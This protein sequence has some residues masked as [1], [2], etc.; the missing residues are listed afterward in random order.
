ML[1]QKELHA[2]RA[3]IFVPTVKPGR[4][5]PRFQSPLR[6]ASELKSAEGARACARAIAV[7]RQTIRRQRQFPKPTMILRRPGPFP[8]QFLARVLH[9][10]RA[11]CRNLVPRIPMLLRG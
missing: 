9:C 3:A 4:A 6:L 1:V 2:I 8:L 11:I 7:P 5:G 10:H